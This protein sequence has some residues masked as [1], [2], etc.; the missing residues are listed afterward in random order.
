MSAPLSNREIYKIL[1]SEIVALK[2]APGEVLTENSLCERFK[3][4]RTPIRSV[5]QRLQ[6]NKF[7]QIVPHKSTTVTPINLEVASQLIYE[8]VAIESMV[9]RD[10]MRMAAPTDVEKVRYSLH[11]MEALAEKAQDVEHFEIYEFLSYDHAMHELWF[12]RTGKDVL[13]QR[14]T[15]PHPDYSRLMRLDVVGA[16]NVA[17]VLTDH[18]E[19]MRMIDTRSEAGIEELMVR[20]LYGNVRRLGGK[21]FSDEYKKYFQPLNER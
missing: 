17:E 7:V 14:I 18:Q 15:R 2:I 19:M 5:L 20:H 1:E 9:F 4:S 3:V 10:F 16:K 6:E 12:L 11:Q 13:W 21:L 8:R